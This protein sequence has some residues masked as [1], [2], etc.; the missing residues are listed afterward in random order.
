MMGWVRAVGAPPAALGGPAGSMGLSVRAAARLGADVAG[1]ARLRAL[2][3]FAQVPPLPG[4][5]S[6]GWW[7]LRHARQWP[8]SYS[9]PS[10]TRYTDH[11]HC[12]PRRALAAGDP[13]ALSP[14]G[15]NGA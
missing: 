9:C 5:A 10:E 8:R 12:R 3:H 13:S 7:G 11:D 4:S 15:K 6:A 2:H 1:I 14:R